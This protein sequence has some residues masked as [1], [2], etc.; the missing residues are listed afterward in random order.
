MTKQEVGYNSATWNPIQDSRERYPYHAPEY[1]SNHFPSFWKA[2]VLLQRE[3]QDT[4]GH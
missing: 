3:V 4:S 1:H 2:V